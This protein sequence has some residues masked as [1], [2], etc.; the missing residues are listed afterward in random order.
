ML[1]VRCEVSPFHPFPLF[2]LLPK[3]ESAHKVERFPCKGVYSG[4]V[5]SYQASVFL[6]LATGVHQ[7]LGQLTR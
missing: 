3:K 1:S 6:P 7:K 2:S 4:M 5:F